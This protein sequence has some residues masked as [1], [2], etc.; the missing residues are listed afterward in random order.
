MVFV[1]F[2]LF[3][4]MY[5]RQLKVDNGFKPILEYKINQEN[6]NKKSTQHSENKF[7]E[8]EYIWDCPDHEKCCDFIFKRFCCSPSKKKLIPLPVPVSSSSS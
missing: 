6:S 4:N 1:T 5:S 2:V 7:V 8:C 3:L